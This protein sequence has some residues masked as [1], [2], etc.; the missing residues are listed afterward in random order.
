MATKLYFSRDTKVY[1]YVPMAAAATKNMYYEL[2]VLDGFS[3][4][5]AMNT[6]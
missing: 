5:Q 3:F 6:S 1:A 4:S 2:P